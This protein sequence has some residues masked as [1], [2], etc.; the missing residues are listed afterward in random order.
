[1]CLQRRALQVVVVADAPQRCLRRQLVGAVLGDHALGHLAREEARRQRVDGDAI[2]APLARQCAREVDD[3]A[4]AG[5]VGDELDVDRA[6]QA[7]DRGDVDDAPLAPR[8]H[9][10]L[11]H[12]LAHQED[13]ADVEVHHL[14]PGFQRVVFGRRAPGGA[15]VVDQDV[16]LAQAAHRFV[17][18]LLDLRRVGRIGCDPACV[19]ALGLQ[20]GGG[21][22][23]VGCL[24]RCE[25]DLG[26]GFAQ[27]FG[28]LQTQATRAAGDDGGLA[29]QVEQLLD[30]CAHAAGL[31]D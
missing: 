12:R 11:A 15:S 20:V 23:Q 24:A 26:A 31:R 5:A 28:N 19:D 17:A 3:R 18:D 13:A 30:R 9:A 29:R 14:V 22:F 6:A 8:D 7:G 10:G 27:R 1:M 25:Q 21:F 4:L 2:G 16:D